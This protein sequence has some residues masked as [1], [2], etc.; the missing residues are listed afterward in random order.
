MADE[1]AALRKRRVLV[2]GAGGFI[3]S[4]LA[5]ALVQAGADVRA[6]VHY[7]SR[8]D[9][10]ALE[11]LAEREAID[12]RA[13]D[14]RDPFHVAELVA[15]IE[16]IFHLAALVAVPYA[17]I[18]PAQFIDTNVIGTL[19]MLEAARRQGVARVVHVSTSEVYGSARAT[20]I[21]E[22]HPLQAQSPYA[23]SK[24]A[25]EKLAE[26]YAHSFATPVVILRPF[27][28][29]GAR[30]S[31]R[32]FL[33]SVL[34]QALTSDVVRVGSL[35]PVRDMNH[36]DDTVRGLLAAATAADVDGL[37]INLGSGR[38]VSM[39]TLL[40][41]AL[42]AAG[43]HTRVEIDPARHRPVASEVAELICDP[44]RARAKLGWQSRITLEEGVRRTAAWIAGHL[45]DY[46][47]ERYAV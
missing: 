31:A 25:A 13:G 41:M 2:T 19:N 34:V 21:D 18:A 5:A 8:S 3:G 12:V 26:S 4:H 45:G 11:Q 14:I 9:W 29:Y 39:S 24:I 32:A 17:Y 40:E 22:Q 46:K 20:P 30:Q 7:N 35:H 42:R 6:L 28:T 47:P 16:I 33:P 10:G 36:V 23:A 38:G 43:R 37:T 15:G 44:S 27:N 1:R